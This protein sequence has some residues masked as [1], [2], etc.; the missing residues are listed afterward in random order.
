[1]T[2]ILIAS[3]A[4]VAAALISAVSYSI[5]YTTAELQ[6]DAYAR[7]EDQCDTTR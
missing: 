7:E 1:M 3:G 2:E 5:A 4:T 6:H